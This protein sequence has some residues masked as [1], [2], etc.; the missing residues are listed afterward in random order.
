MRHQGL[1]DL[2]CICCLKPGLEFGLFAVLGLSVLERGVSIHPEPR[3]PGHKDP[4]N[5]TFL[6]LTAALMLP[7][8]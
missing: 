2:V 4:S 7:F 8:V 6:L 5:L 3:L 1:D